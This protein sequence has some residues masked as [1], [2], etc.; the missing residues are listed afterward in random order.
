MS[1]TWKV[2]EL[3][4]EIAKKA[5]PASILQSVVENARKN[6]DFR[7][8]ISVGTTLDTCGATYMFPLETIMAGVNGTAQEVLD[9]LR[10]G[11]TENMS[12]TLENFEGK[13]YLS[14]FQHR[15]DKHLADE[16]R[17]RMR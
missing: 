15:T 11:L 17:R 16:L 8:V 9:Y 10:T 13:Q 2:A 12:A 1:E 5:D 4:E 3:L 14:I 6:D 7:F